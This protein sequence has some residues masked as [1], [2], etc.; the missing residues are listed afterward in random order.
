MRRLSKLVSVFVIGPVDFD[1]V[2]GIREENFHTSVA[3]V[4]LHDR[5]VAFPEQVRS[6]FTDN[7][8]RIPSV[9]FFVLVGV[10]LLEIPLDLFVL[11]PLFKVVL[12]RERLDQRVPKRCKE[13]LRTKRFA[14]FLTS[15]RF[16]GS[17]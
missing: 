5:V 8:L 2:V 12:L 6:I 3:A 15:S 4:P 17:F 14:D 11:P 10:V 13:E 9:N 7:F 16:H 1:G